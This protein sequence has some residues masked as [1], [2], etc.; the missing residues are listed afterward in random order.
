MTRSAGRYAWIVL[1]LAL[2]LLPLGGCRSRAQAGR[3]E[4]DGLSFDYPA[5]WTVKEDKLTVKQE[6]NR[7]M[8]TVVVHGPDHGVITMLIFTGNVPISLESFARDVVKGTRERLKEKLT[9]AGVSMGAETDATPLAPTERS[10]AG[11]KVRGLQSHSIVRVL[12]VPMPQTT[13]FFLVDLAGHKVVFMAQV[14]DDD[15]PKDGAAI[16]KIL[17]SVA[18]GP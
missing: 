7:S 9:V 17:D 6:T 13:D 2:A 18:L 5:G 8:R 15:R 3:Y 11:T 12:N 10:I 1:G 16:Q 4:R 14:F